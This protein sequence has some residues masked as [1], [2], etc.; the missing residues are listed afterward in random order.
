MKSPIGFLL[1]AIVLSSLP[2]AAED[3]YAKL[4]TLKGREYLAVTVSKVEPDGLRIR[5]E[6][7]TAKLL[8]QD[9][10]EDVRTKY[11]YDPAAGEHFRKQAEAKAAAQESAL[12]AEI[13]A[14]TSASKQAPQ[15]P[16]TNSPSAS[17]ADSGAGPKDAPLVVKLAAQTV[18]TARDKERSWETSWGSYDQS[19]YRSR[20]VRV[21]LQCTDGSGPATLYLQWVGSVS[22]SPSTQG[23][24]KTMQKDVTLR[25]GQQVSHEFAELFVE[26]DAKYA[27]L[28]IRD[29]DGLK[30]SGWIARLIA[31]NRRIIAQQAARPPMLTRFPPP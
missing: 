24:V 20:I 27:A 11:D 9:L 19:I 30:Y 18:A 2:L 17:P 10:P 23:V 29:R 4:T 1:I 7:G 21:S 16:A 14:A 28:G 31:P 12:S 15:A 6:S 5:H 26:N 25:A 13:A 8:F 3:S 22:G